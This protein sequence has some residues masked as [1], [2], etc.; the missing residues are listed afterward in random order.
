[1][2]LNNQKREK[3]EGY[4][5]IKNGIEGVSLNPLKRGKEGTS[6]NP[7]KALVLFV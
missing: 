7:S 1:M 3:R 4:L 2:L 6:L 5:I